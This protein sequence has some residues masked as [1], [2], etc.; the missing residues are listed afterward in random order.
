LKWVVIQ[1]ICV[2]TSNSTESFN[3]LNAIY[4]V[5]KL[6]VQNTLED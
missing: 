5:Q 1:H 4:F 3:L 2:L 6:N